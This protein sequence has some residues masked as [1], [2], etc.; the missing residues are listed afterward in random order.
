MRDVFLLPFLPNYRAVRSVLAERMAK[1][2]APHLL[3]CSFSFIGKPSLKNCPILWERRENG[4]IDALEIRWRRYELPSVWIDFRPFEHPDDMVL[5]DMPGRGIVPDFGGMRC[6]ATPD[7]KEFHF[8]LREALFYPDK[9]ASRVVGELKSAV[10][11]ISEFLRGGFP[12]PNAIDSSAWW[13]FE[14]KNGPP[15]WPELPVHLPTVR[16]NRRF[17]PPNFRL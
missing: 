7:C 4:R 1:E 14:L 12:P 13:L 16:T 6:Y 8:T 17:A 3:S 5:W 11:Q 10:S 15:P 9:G 2:L